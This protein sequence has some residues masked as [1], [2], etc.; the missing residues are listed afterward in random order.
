MSLI[1]VTD[2]VTARDY[3]QLGPVYEARSGDGRLVRTMGKARV[4]RIANVLRKP[5]HCIDQSGVGQSIPASRPSLMPLFNLDAERA[6][7]PRPHLSL[8]TRLR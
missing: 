4:T 8:L 6:G 7:G 3:P 1:S 2:S 5:D